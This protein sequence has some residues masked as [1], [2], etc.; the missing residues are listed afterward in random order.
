MTEPMPPCG[1][2]PAPEHIVIDFPVNVVALGAGLQLLN[3]PTGLVPW[4]ITDQP[5]W[6]RITLSELPSNKTL[7][8]GGLSYGDGRGYPTPSRPARP[9]ITTIVPRR[10]AGQTWLCN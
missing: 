3:V 8:A 9:K 6:V 2:T 7:N 4:Q 1:Q 5:A 10:Q